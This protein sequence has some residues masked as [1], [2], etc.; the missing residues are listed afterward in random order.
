MQ[1]WP[2]SGFSRVPRNP[3]SRPRSFIS[4]RWEPRASGG[5]G[6]VRGAGGG[7]GGGVGSWTEQT[8]A[9]PHCRPRLL[10]RDAPS[11]VF[12]G[13]WCFPHVN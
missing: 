4:H 1:M 7:V 3:A 8:W 5:E 9:H 13:I 6:R 10:G 2:S 12:R 11:S